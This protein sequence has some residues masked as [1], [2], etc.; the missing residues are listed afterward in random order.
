MRRYEVD[1]IGPGSCRTA[2]FGKNGV[3]PF[4]LLPTVSYLLRNSVQWP[5]RMKYHFKIP[6]LYT[7]PYTSIRACLQ[8]QRYLNYF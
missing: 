2:D 6:T 5:L 4:D 7:F 3:E 1:G 8:K